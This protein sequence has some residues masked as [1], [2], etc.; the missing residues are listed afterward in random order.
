MITY[1]S[2]FLVANLLVCNAFAMEAED[3]AWSKT[4]QMLRDG[5]YRTA[6]HAATDVYLDKVTISDATAT[7]AELDLLKAVRDITKHIKTES[8][9]GEKK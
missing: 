4:A 7:Q 8:K 9:D 1:L 2:C 6:L 5:Y 3:I